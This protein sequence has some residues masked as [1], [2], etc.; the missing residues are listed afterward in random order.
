MDN[1]VKEMSPCEK[2]N[3]NKAAAGVKILEELTELCKDPQKYN[4]ELLMKILIRKKCL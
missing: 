2:S 4:N 1:P 3:R